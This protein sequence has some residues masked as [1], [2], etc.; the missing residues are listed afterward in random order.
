M[1]KL[2]LA[3]ITLTTAASVF[4]QGTVTFNNRI[5]GTGITHIYSGPAYLY[6]NSAGDSPTGSVSY[7]GYLLI[8]TTGGLVGSTT[9]AQLLGANGAGAPESSL[10]PSSSPPTTF[11]TGAAAGF[12]AGTTATFNNIPQ[13][14]ASGS[15]ELA[16]WDN[17]SGLYPTWT[18]A[19]AALA[20]G[21]LRI[22]GRSQEFTLSQIGG[23]TFTPPAIV[24][25]LQSF[26]IAVPEPTTIALA[27]LSA[28]ALLIFRRRK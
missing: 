8:G 10:V 23:T 13:D 27:G 19:S 28:A 7:A 25:A 17:S 24:P 14:A 26:G 9:F 11:R 12:V 5:T 20:S 22:G 18:Q 2:I 16:V 21:A 6:G 1:K 3:A 15:F 4:A